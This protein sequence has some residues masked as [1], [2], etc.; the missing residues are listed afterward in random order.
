M[1][2]EK[3]QF[4]KTKPS[5]EAFYADAFRHFEA[6][7]HARK[8]SDTIIELG[9]GS[10]LIKDYLPN[11]KATDISF[12][13][14]L[15]LCLDGTKIELKSESVDAFFA[16]NVLH[17]IHDKFKFFDEVSRCLKPGGLLFIRDQHIS[18]VS[19]LIF[20]YLHHEHFDES[21]NIWKIES[22][23][24]TENGASAHVIFNKERQIFEEKWGDL[25][26][27]KI[28][29]VSAMYYWLSGGL[30]KWTM[31]PSS[32]TS[33]LISLDSRLAKLC[34]F[35]CSFTDIQIIKK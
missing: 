15:D 23:N 14:D 1:P 17:H 20:K 32:L 34:P 21:N 25:E 4:I 16:M 19:R 2:E 35:L 24:L 12:Q 31:I 9:S 8:L 3:Y 33:P 28:E 30:K 7:L 10:R 26:I 5:L 6:V 22:E 11:A 13:K 29:R 27:I 18:L